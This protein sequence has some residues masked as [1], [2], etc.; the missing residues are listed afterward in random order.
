MKEFNTGHGHVFPRPDGFKARCGGPPLCF[1]CVADAAEK[2]S[3]RQSIKQSVS[4]DTV[5]DNDIVQI[6]VRVFPKNNKMI[7]ND[8]W[9]TSLEWKSA[10]SLNLNIIKRKVDEALESFNKDDNK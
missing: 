9:F 3:Q 7:Q 8:C 10:G 1:L 5:S 4:S 2:A 6:I